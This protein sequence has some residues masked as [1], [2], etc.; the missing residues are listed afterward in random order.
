MKYQRQ[1]TCKAPRELTAGRLNRARSCARC[2]WQREEGWS[3]EEGG[4]SAWGG[5]LLGFSAWLLAGT[6]TSA[7]LWR[8]PR[9]G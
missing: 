9:T 4:R 7:L 8:D 6:V 2:E 3:G 5:R 1:G